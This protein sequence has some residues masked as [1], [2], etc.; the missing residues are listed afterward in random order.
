MVP[1]LYPDIIDT[2]TEEDRICT[3]YPCFNDLTPDGRMAYNK[4]EWPLQSTIDDRSDHEEE[5]EEAEMSSSFA[6]RKDF[7]RG[8]VLD[9]RELPGI[10]IDLSQ[11][12]RL[13]LKPSVVR[14][15]QIRHDS[16]QGR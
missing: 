9:L 15:T 3:A 1:R 16:G 11:V 13:E 6:T 4:R 7:N 14:T 2:Y 8:F 10:A 5:E 12:L